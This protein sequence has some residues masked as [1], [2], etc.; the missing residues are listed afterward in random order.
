MITLTNRLGATLTMQ[1][2]MSIDETGH[3]MQID[4]ERLAHGDGSIFCGESVEPRS[5]TAKGSLYYADKT[6]N[7]VKIDELNQFLRYA[8]IEVDRG[9]GRNILARKKSFVSK[10]LDDDIEVE[11]T[12]EFEALDPYFYGSPVTVEQTVTTVDTIAIASLGEAYPVITLDITGSCTD[13]TLTCDGQSIIVA[14]TYTTGK[15]IIDSKRM[16]ATYE[17]AGII[18]SMNDS[19]LNSSFLI[20]KDSTSIAFSATGSYSIDITIDF[21]PRFL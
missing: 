12:I 20:T 3:T 11:L 19:W 15:I 8:P 2:T 9:D 1:M 16:R 6:I 5:F 10:W 21:R 18:G 17:G 14:G 7:R 4:S 13:P